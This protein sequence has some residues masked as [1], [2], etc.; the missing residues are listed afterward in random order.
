LLSLFGYGKRNR[1][2]EN[3]MGLFVIILFMIVMFGLGVF[4]GAAIAA[5]NAEQEEQA[6]LVEYDD[7]RGDLSQIFSDEF[8]KYEKRMVA[9]RRTEDGSL[10]VKIGEVDSVDDVIDKQLDPTPEGE[11]LAEAHRRNPDEQVPDR[12]PSVVTPEEKEI[13]KERENQRAEG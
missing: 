9:L 11:A 10:D 1:F 2:G 6:R 12:G 7:L 3:Q 5:N 4:V 8:D 13:L